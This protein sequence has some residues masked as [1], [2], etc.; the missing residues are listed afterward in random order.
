M[1]DPRAGWESL[2]PMAD[3]SDTVV[4]GRLHQQRAAPWHPAATD[5]GTAACA[6]SLYPRSEH[7]GGRPRPRR[8]RKELRNLTPREYK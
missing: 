8:V 7:F 1:G 6:A 3:Q 5:H 2:Q 4:V